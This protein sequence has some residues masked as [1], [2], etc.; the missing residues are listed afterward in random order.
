M[1]KENKVQRNV[2]EM[3]KIQAEY[4]GRKPEYINMYFAFRLKCL[5]TVLIWLTVVL[6]VLTATQI[7]L[8]ICRGIEQ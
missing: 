7:G 2:K 3:D 4:G 1:T 8:L 5:T 6:T